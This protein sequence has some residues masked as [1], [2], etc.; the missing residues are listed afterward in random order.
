I[1][2]DEATTALTEK[3][4][5]SL[6]TV[7]HNIRS[8]GV[9]VLFVSHKLNEVL[10]IADKA[11]IIRNGKVVLDAEARD[12][13]RTKL[14][15]YMTGREFGVGSYEFTPAAEQDTPLLSVKN[16]C[17]GDNF[18]DISFEMRHGEILGI[19]GLLGS[20][21]T[22][23]ALSLFGVLPADSGEILVEGKH[24]SIRSIQSAVSHG[25]GYV[26]EDRLTE[27]LFLEQSI[28]KNMI[29]CTV[30]SLVGKNGLL[31]RQRMA[32]QIRSWIGSLSIKT[33]DA[34]LPAKSLS[35]G[36]QQRVVLAKWLAS[37][38]RILILNGPTVGVDVGSKVEL[39]EIIKDLARKGVGIL[40][41]SDDIPE[42][43][44]TC[45]RILVMRRGRL[46]A[47]YQRQQITEQ[48]LTY[49]LTEA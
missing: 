19:T 9:A 39:H 4:I 38:P 23:L 34:E 12:L 35:G 1:I 40:I 13:D 31:N 21:R 45:N 17:A 6:F 15:F 37:N 26:P 7:I 49:K 25:I 28:G 3:E 30:D 2:M 36:N 8:E 32:D 47:H 41:I 46:V 44:E 33:R 42:L 14:T 22:E 11:L 16:L 29:V 18:Q 10:E 20:G 5:R 43:L 27:G 48:E 24:A